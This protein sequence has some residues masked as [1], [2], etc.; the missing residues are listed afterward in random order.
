MGLSRKIFEM[1][2]CTNI[3]SLSFSLSLERK[4]PDGGNT[5]RLNLG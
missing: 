1:S 5:V 2:L 4:G 3:F